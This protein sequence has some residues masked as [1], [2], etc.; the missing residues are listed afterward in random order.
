M[1][2]LIGIGVFVALVLLV[3]CIFAFVWMSS[4]NKTAPRI[5]FIAFKKFYLISPSNWRL[6]YDDSVEY[7]GDHGWMYIE[8]KHYIDAVRYGFFK[9]KVK[10][11]GEYLKKIR[12]ERI[13]IASVQK[14]IDSYR[15]ENLAELERIINDAQSNAENILQKAEVNSGGDDY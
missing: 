9:R 2:I 14:D 4:V 15:R 8:F 13:F 7:Y 11:D 6:Y 3:Y 10:R 5:S 12:N 1:K